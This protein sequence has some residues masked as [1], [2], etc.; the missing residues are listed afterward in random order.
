MSLARGALDCAE[1]RAAL[2]APPDNSVEQATLDAHVASCPACAAFA[3]HARAL[4][5]LL[6]ASLVV[7][8]PAMLS[9]QLVALARA[10]AHPAAS[11]THV[12]ALPPSHVRHSTP[13]ERVLVAAFGAVAAVTLTL[14]GLVSWD[15]TLSW[16]NDGLVAAQILL[17]SPALALL[18]D[19]AELLARYG[20]AL[21][22]I[23]LAWGLREWSAVPVR[24]RP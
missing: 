24:N 16:L 4:D 10:A 23:P 11:P 14:L 5:E 12:A 2:L 7:A 8:P 17:T 20:P 21:A 15:A 1:A 9:A 13:L 3:T 18:P 19:P 22:L 6:A